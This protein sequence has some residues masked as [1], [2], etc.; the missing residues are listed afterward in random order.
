SC[1]DLKI[2][3]VSRER[4]TIEVSQPMNILSVGQDM[5]IEIKD[6]ETASGVRILSQTQET[7][8]G[9][10]QMFDWGESRRSIEKI[11]AAFERSL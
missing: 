6:L 4:G 7:F 1:E 3:A 8:L 9:I 2:K 10:R 5:V 11:I